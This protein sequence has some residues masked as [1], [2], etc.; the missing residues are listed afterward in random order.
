MAQKVLKEFWESGINR[1][2][3]DDPESC[4][5]WIW[6]RTAWRAI[7]WRRRKRRNLARNAE[8]Q[9]D[10]GLIAEE[11]RGE[12]EALVER[13]YEPQAEP[14]RISLEGLVDETVAYARLMR[15]GFSVLEEAIFREILIGGELQR[16]FA[17]DHRIPI[18]TVGRLVIEV[19]RKLGGLFGSERGFFNFP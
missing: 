10:P 2:D 9:N 12:G 3:E 6:A 1:C 13:R 19:R 17:Q 5:R 11:I 15:G 7:D 16:D 8:P 4:G 18:G 14:V